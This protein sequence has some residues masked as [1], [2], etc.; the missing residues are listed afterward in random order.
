[1]DRAGGALVRLDHKSGGGEN[2]G[3]GRGRGPAEIAVAISREQSAATEGEEPAALEEGIKSGFS[4]PVGL[5]F[6]EACCHLRH[7]FVS[8]YIH[9]WRWG[10]MAF[11]D[12][13]H[14]GLSDYNGS[15]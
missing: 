5:R 15:S 6:G 12:R 9:A 1:M 13:P 3:Q 8:G 14:S 7:T 11:G 4:E 10:S 2:D